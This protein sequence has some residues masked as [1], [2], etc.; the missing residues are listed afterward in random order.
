MSL[1]IEPTRCPWC[2]NPV[3]NGGPSQKMY[4]FLFS[5]HAS[6]WRNTSCTIATKENAALSFALFVAGQG[7]GIAG[8]GT[9][10]ETVDGGVR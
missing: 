2:G 1:S 3:A 5:V 7:I 4:G 8:R 6:D 9:L 10:Q